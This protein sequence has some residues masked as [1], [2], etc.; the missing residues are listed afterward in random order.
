MKAPTLKFD[1]EFNA[2]MTHRQMTPGIIPNESNV[3]GIARTPRPIWV[4][5]IRTIVPVQPTFDPVSPLRYTE[6]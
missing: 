1:Q 4:F 6:N 2:A 5:I 3:V